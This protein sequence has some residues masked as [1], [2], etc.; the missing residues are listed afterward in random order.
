MTSSPLTIMNDLR[1]LITRE[2]TSFCI[3]CAG[4]API[5]EIVAAVLAQI[6]ITIAHNHNVY[7]TKRCKDATCEKTNRIIHH[8]TLM[9]DAKLTELLPV[10]CNSTAEQFDYWVWQ[11]AVMNRINM[12]MFNIIGEVLA[13]NLSRHK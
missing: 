11:A 4:S 1:D 3:C 13:Q 2:V 5:D 9:V 6:K 7:C 10:A 8:M 12:E